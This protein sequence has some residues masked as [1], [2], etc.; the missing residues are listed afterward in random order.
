MKKQYA[1][2]L[3]LVLAAS[4]FFSAS[5]WSGQKKLSGNLK[6][7]GVSSLNELTAKLDREI[8]AVDAKTAPFITVGEPVGFII[9]FENGVKFYA[10][11]DT[12][13][14]ADMKLVVGDFYKPDVA[15]LPIGNYYTMD[16]KAAAYAASLINPARYVVPI[17]FA[18]FPFLEPDTDRFFSELTKY[19]LRAQPLK[20]T[21]GEP[22]DVLGIKTLWLGHGDWIYES[23]EGTKIAVDPEVAYNGQFPDAYKDLSRFERIDLILISHGH[24]DHMTVPDLKKW[25]KLFDPII[26][27]PFEAGVWLK[28]NL[29]TKNILAI[30][31]GADI[32]KEE[33]AATGLPADKINKMADIR[34]NLVPAAHSSSVTPEN[35]PAKY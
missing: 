4:L 5:S 33:M 20:F 18:S 7:S 32:G 3:I 11:G 22:R 24:F 14:M 13:V 2:L 21:V 12:G 17:H 15:F 29:P 9:T 34:I 10:A 31:K 23:P 19:N 6:E 1:A 35:N 28:D 8:K 26:I 25:V 16:Y 27:A 30:N